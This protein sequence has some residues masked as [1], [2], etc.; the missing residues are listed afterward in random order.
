LSVSVVSTHEANAI[1]DHHDDDVAAAVRLAIALS[2]IMQEQL[3]Q[4]GDEM[5]RFE[6]PAAS[7]ADDRPSSS[8]DLRACE[9]VVVMFIQLKNYLGSYWLAPW[10]FVYIYPSIIVYEWV[11]TIFTFERHRFIVGPRQWLLVG[12]RRLSK[13]PPGLKIEINWSSSL[14]L[15]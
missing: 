2:S 1:V 7:S 9:R 12:C 5:D 8:H 6:C 14:T 13:I 11:R 10:F 3:V 15:L 4:R